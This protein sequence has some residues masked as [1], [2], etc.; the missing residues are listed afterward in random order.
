[1]SS[2]HHAT[3]HVPFGQRRE[4]CGPDFWR[5]KVML[6]PL[7]G[8][9]DYPMR[10]MARRFGADLTYTEMISSEALT[11]HHP[12]TYEILPEA[13]ETDRVFVQLFGHR[14]EAMAEAA[15]IVEAHGALGID[16][17]L[18]CPTPKITASGAGAALLREPEKIRSLLRAM[19]QSTRL[20]ITLKLRSGWE[21][22]DFDTVLSIGRMAAEEGCQ[23][24]TLHPRSRREG[25][26]GRADWGMIRRLVDSCPLPV[27]GNGDVRDGPSAAALFEQTGCEAIMVGRGA[28]GYPWIFSEIRAFLSQYRMKE[29][30]STREK[31][32]RAIEHLHLAV[33]KYGRVRA[34]RTMRKHLAW[35]LK[36][37]PG[38]KEYR[39]QVVQMEDVESL[40]PLLREIPDSPRHS[41]GL[42]RPSA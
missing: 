33:A 13:S 22:P 9:T 6:A 3:S 31:I 26:S 15:N 1:M 8:V 11:R 21:C 2:P 25:F 42:R 18:G 20:P 19:R 16:V 17:N 23:A 36:G 32:E 40:E 38:A 29:P 35:Y 7:A 28:M 30:P 24:L 39:A 27:I 4:E 41:L 14:P 37:I 12:R 5:G 34:V 10:E